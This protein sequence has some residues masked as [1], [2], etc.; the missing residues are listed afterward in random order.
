LETMLPL[1]LTA[2]HAGKLRYEDIARLCCEGPARAYDIKR[3]GRIAKGFDADLTL[4]D[5]NAEWRIGDKPL[6]TKCNWSPFAGWPVQGTVK[7]VFVR[8]QLA[9]DGGKVVMDKGSGQQV[10]NW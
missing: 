3:K 2:A 8:G 10:R 1:L 6:L 9:F 4:V 5:P 7:Q